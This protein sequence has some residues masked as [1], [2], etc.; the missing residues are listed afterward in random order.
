MNM[1]EPENDPAGGASQEAEGRTGPGPDAVE[2]GGVGGRLYKPGDP[3]LK[4]GQM[5]ETVDDLAAL[6][7][8][9]VGDKTPQGPASTPTADMLAGNETVP[10]RLGGRAPVVRELLDPR[11]IEATLTTLSGQDVALY[12]GRDTELPDGVVIGGPLSEEVRAAF[13]KARSDPVMGFLGSVLGGPSVVLD[14]KEREATPNTKPPVDE[15]PIWGSSACEKL[16]EEAF[17]GATA[18]YVYWASAPGWVNRIE[19]TAIIKL[20]KDFNRLLKDEFGVRYRERPASRKARVWYPSADELLSLIERDRD[21]VRLDRVAGIEFAPGQPSVFK[22]PE[23][24]GGKMLLNTWHEP[25]RCASASMA[26]PRLFEAHVRYICNG[27]EAVADH[28]LDWVAHLVQRPGERVNHAVLIVSKAQGVG[29]SMLGDVVGHLA[30]ESNRASTTAGILGSGFDGLTTGKLVVQVDE[31]REAGNW[32]LAE[33][34]KSK[35]TEERLPVNI[36]Y[37]PQTIVRN[38]TR[39]LMFSN[40]IDA[41][42]LQEGERR[43]FVVECKQ[44]PREGAYYGKLAEDLLTPAGIEGVRRWLLV[45]DLSRFKPKASPPLTEAKAAMIESSE[46]PLVDYL[47]SALEDR[48]LREALGHRVNVETQEFSGAALQDVLRTTNFAHHAKNA[49]ELGE[50]LRKVGFTQRRTKAA[51][52]WRF[53]ASHP[54]EPLADEF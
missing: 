37:G 38:F 49:S 28:L 42:S 7:G 20:D 10:D 39:W 17:A 2:K 12:M 22:G 29:K 32:K 50:A 13:E 36:K 35:I 27:D 24:S 11:E 5:F 26:S 40:H 47:R 15:L 43:F 41:L 44:Q 19:P 16:V 51:R 54:I 21:D 34:L 6:V 53:P 14:G 33:S 45:R 18:K 48:S 9:E 8:I 25:M 1:D 30:G 31:V 23:A 4:T 3:E 46:N 52:F